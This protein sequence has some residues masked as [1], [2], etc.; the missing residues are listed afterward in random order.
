MAF[1]R[2]KF[3]KTSVQ[4]I[5]KI[6]KKAEATMPTMGGGGWI[7]FVTIED[8][9]NVFRVCPSETG[10]AY[11][12]VKT[13]KL[14]VEKPV[15]D[16]DGNIT[17]REVKDA[18]IFCADVHGADILG[19]KDP[20]ITYIKYVYALADDIQDENEKAKFLLPITGYFGK[21][22]WEW[23]ISPILGYVCYVNDNDEVKKLQLRPQW[24]KDMKNES[25]KASSKDTLSLDIFSDPTEGYPL[26]IEKSYET[27][28]KG[29]KK[30]K[31]LV[32]ALPLER[33]KD[34]E[35]FFQESA[36]SDS[37]LEK[38]SN[39]PSLEQTYVN[40]YSRKDWDYALDGLQR[41]DEDH[42]FNIFSDD[43]FLDELQSM[44]S[45]LPEE[46]AS[47]EKETSKVEKITEKT[48]T[49]SREVARPAASA[50]AAKL[51]NYPSLIKMKAFLKEY[52]ETEYEDTEKLP[53]SLSLAELRQWYDLAQEGMMLPFD[54]YKDEGESDPEE[55]PNQEDSALNQEELKPSDDLAAARNRL[56]NLTK[57]RRG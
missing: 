56:A 40:C 57:T 38:L 5:E 47:E 54:D 46:E 24:M 9:L 53:E 16:K 8:G 17:G 29:K 35:S 25:I 13:A 21:K 31:F 44:E 36:L 50:P 15:Y 30:A 23:G 7:P 28:K 52:I 3:K 37:F 49:P 41:F 32:Y 11:A 22:G 51:S 39:A 55:T 48:K 43:A 45:L 42:G 19:G 34:W 14:Q 33:G 1:D 18:N 6:S 20:I 2:S 10:M 4:E 26:C 12:P 27:D